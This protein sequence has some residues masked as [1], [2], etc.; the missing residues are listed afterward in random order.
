MV[1]ALDRPEKAQFYLVTFAYGSPRKFKRFTNWDSDIDPQGLN[2]ISLPRM[3]INLAANE[4][5]FQEDPTKL[6]MFID[7]VTS[8]LLDPL[9][10]GT[11]FAPVAVQIEEIIDPIKIGDAGSTQV[12]MRG[13]VYRTRRH[14]DGITNLCV[15]EV[16]N[17]KSLLDV[18]LGFQVNANCVWRLNGVGCTESTHSP[19]GY[20]TRSEE[21]SIDGKILSIEDVSLIFDL[22]GTRNWT[23]GF[24]E[25]DDLRIGIFYYDKATFDGQVTKEFQLVRQPPAEWEGKTITFF[26][27]CT[28][29]I[30]SDGGCRSAW[31]NEEGFGG[32]GFAIPAYNPITENPA[33]P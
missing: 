8:D 3:E 14:A 5:T 33:G 17:Q 9:S 12:V 10:R 4:G 7:S 31:D 29:Q 22:A 13:H 18:P 24:V 28:K 21:V 25:F 32:S 16:R 2:F 23:R 30:D 27:G 26:P 11:P 6:K 19:S 20:V 15:I 1:E